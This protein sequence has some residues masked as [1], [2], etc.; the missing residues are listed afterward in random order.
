MLSSIVITWRYAAPH[1]QKSSPAQS[2]WHSEYFYPANAKETPLFVEKQLVWHIAEQPYLMLRDLENRTDR[3]LSFTNGIPV[4]WDIAP[5][6]REDHFY[7]FV[8]RTDDGRLWRT[9]LDSQGALGLGIIE[10]A[11]NVQQA[12]ITTGGDGQ[13]V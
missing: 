8:W 12:Q 3:K 6:L 11:T 5:T 10:V 7:H 1:V 2:I 13:T 4:W 9:L